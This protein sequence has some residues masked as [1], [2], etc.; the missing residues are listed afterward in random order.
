MNSNWIN[1]NILVY[2]DLINMIFKGIIVKFIQMIIFKNEN[3]SKVR[4]NLK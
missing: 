1:T 3:I 2:I 4:N